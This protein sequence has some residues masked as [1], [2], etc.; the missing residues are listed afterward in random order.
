MYD[1]AI[2]P[3]MLNTS[4]LAVLGATWPKDK[5]NPKMLTKEQVAELKTSAIQMNT[6]GKLNAAIAELDNIDTS[7]DDAIRQFAYDNQ[8]K[9]LGTIGQAYEKLGYPPGSPT[10]AFMRQNQL[11]SLQI[12]AIEGEIH[13][14]PILMFIDRVQI[15]TTNN[16]PTFSNS[17]VIVIG[18][19]K[20]FPQLVL[21]SNQNDKFFLKTRSANID[22]SQK[23]NL[24]GNFSHFFDFY[25]PKDISANTLTVLAPN[26]MQLLID[27]SA[28]F[29][30]EVFGD[31]L[32]IM[33]H[34]PLF[35]AT[36]MNEAIQALDAQL[37]YMHRLEQSWSYQPK[38]PPL[39][40]THSSQQHRPRTLYC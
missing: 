16:K 23:M 1:S 15:G 13:G 24:E 7:A 17:G 4:S 38:Q 30:V 25:A 21:G 26:F 31:R 20:I 3:V 8:W 10:P 2:I 32:Y 22:A 28:T 12:R 11:L 39:R 6:D 19:H 34:D 18:L 35:T 40:H 36:I 29:D 9:Y 27:S 37:Q 33:T 14:F 5:D